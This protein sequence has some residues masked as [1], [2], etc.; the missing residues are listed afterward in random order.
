[1]NI[2][3][4]F[5]IIMLPGSYMG[6]LEDKIE[7]NREA[8]EALAQSDLRSSKYAKQLLDNYEGYHQT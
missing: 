3:V 1:M 8:L 6:S 2:T 5:I 7:Q 4:R